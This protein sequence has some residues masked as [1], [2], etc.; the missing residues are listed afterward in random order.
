MVPRVPQIMNSAWYKA[1]AELLNYLHK[2][3]SGFHFTVFHWPVYFAVTF[4]ASS[5]THCWIKFKTSSISVSAVY[6]YTCTWT[7]PPEIRFPLCSYFSLS[8]DT[9]LLF[10]F[11][12]VF[13]SWS[14]SFTSIPP[15]FSLTEE[16]EKKLTAYRR[17]S[18]F[19]RMLIFC[20]VR[21]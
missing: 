1:H 3:I 13:L 17:G 6:Y 15:F 18:K 8:L 20:Q 12:S 16:I 21:N 5:S 4:H 7:H 19:W 9:F 11:L 10:I 14:L 2:Y